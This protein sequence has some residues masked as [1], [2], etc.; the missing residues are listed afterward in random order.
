MKKMGLKYSLSKN[1]T[2]AKAI[3]NF[4]ADDHNNW[5]G[6]TVADYGASGIISGLSEFLPI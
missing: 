1:G 3:I 2:S 4:L 6:K 5:L